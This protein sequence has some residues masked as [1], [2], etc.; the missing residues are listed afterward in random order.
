MQQAD[1]S[2]YKSVAFVV[3]ET[4]GLIYPAQHF[5]KNITQ[6]VRKYSTNNQ[7]CNMQPSHL[8]FQLSDI[9]FSM[10]SFIV[11]KPTFTCKKIA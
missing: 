1:K 11:S 8:I 4:R 5:L 2:D 10:V 9:T 7:E 3:V 6:E